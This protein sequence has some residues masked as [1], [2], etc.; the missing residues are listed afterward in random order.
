MP[1]INEHIVLE[2]EDLDRARECRQAI[3]NEFGGCRYWI[4]IIKTT[5]KH[6]V[7]L[8]NNWGAKLSDDEA[9]PVIEFSNKFK[10][11]KGN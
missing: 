11:S 7:T 9:Q 10:E 2:T 3:M 1:E 6:V 5:K 8:A 4:C